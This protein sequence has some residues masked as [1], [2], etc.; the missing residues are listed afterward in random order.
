MPTVITTPLNLDLTHAYLAEVGLSPLVSG[1][2]WTMRFQVRQDV[3]GVAT[4]NPVSLDGATVVLEIFDASSGVVLL[5]RTSG[6]AITGASP[7]ANQIDIDADQ[8]NE[9]T[10][11]YT[12][13]GWFEVHVR[14][15]TGDNQALAAAKGRRR[16]RILATLPDS[17]DG[18]EQQVAGGWI[19]VG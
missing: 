8:E 14:T 17:G 10:V 7:A 4:T 15:S 1:T 3:E 16:Y 13:M 18:D 5:S 19:E 11:D 12:G 2:D 9:D 6:T